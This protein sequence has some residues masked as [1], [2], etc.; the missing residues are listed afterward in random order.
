MSPSHTPGDPG[1]VRRV[2]ASSGLRVRSTVSRE[3]L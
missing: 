3:K 1:V 2:L